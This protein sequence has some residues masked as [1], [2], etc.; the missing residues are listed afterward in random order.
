[1]GSF[2]LITY[3]STIGNIELIKDRIKQYEDSINFLD[4]SWFVFSE[5]DAGA[6]YNKLSKGEFE[7]DLFLVTKVDFSSYWGRL[8][9]TVWDWIKKERSK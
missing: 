4:N 6:I 2:Y 7:N 8:N 3:S 9:K 5:E 1:M